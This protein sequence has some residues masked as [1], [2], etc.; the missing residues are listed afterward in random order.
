MYPV[1]KAPIPI[2]VAKSETSSGLNADLRSISLPFLVT[3]FVGF[4]LKFGLNNF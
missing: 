1:R 2:A 4:Y 3:S